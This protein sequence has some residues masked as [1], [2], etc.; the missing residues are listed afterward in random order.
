MGR[1]RSAAATPALLAAL[2]FLVALNLRPAIAAVGPV[3]TRIGGDLGWGESLLG[4]LGAMPLWA[5]AV[6][7]PLVRF[8]TARIGADRTILAALLVLAVGDVARSFGGPTGVWLG[9]VAAGAGIAAGN[10]LVP[11]IAKRDYAGHV[12]MATGV[13]SACITTGSAIA[14]LTAA[15]LADMLGGWRPALAL[16]AAPPVIVAALWSIRV[17][18]GTSRASDGS[19]A[20]PHDPHE[21]RGT[22]VSADSC[23]KSAA[24]AASETAVASAKPSDAVAVES[25]AASLPLWRRPMTWWVTLFMGL[26]SAAF[27]TMSNWLP[28]VVTAAGFSDAT[29]G[30]HLFVFQSL[31]ILSGLM[32]PALMQVRGNQVCAAVV[33]SVPMVVSGLGWMAAPGLSLLWGVIGGMGQ[34]AALV[35]A[36]TL[37]S[38]RGRT[39]EETVALSGMAQ[40]IGY[41]LA[42]VGPLAFGT[43]AELSEGWTAPLVLF[44]ALAAVQC[45]VAV[46]AG[47]DPARV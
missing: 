29:A 10:V 18:R 36:L 40:S 4:V 15:P 9:T 12:S 37:I 20:T 1:S 17:M 22:G 34:G 44:T 35:V 26:Q 28:S 11:V 45:V 13:Y 6:V 3:L 27:Y 46:L 24:G 23:A 14:G 33:S 41:L 21:S 32:I 8:V 47:R 2:I 5:F 39:S 42:S 43:L 30:V 19:S 7:S 38:L 25:A 31:G 16:W